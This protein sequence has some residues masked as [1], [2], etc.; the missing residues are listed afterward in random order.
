M[1]LPPSG[2]STFQRFFFTFIL[3]LW[4]QE[5]ASGFEARSVRGTDFVDF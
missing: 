3:N 4:K 1:S 2:E 5:L